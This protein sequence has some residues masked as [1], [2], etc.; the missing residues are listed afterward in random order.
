M[1]PALLSCHSDDEGSI[2]VCDTSAIQGSSLLLI[3]LDTTRADALGCYGGA[4]WVTRNLDE[5]AKQGVRFTQAWTV[6]PLTLPSHATILTGLLPFEHGVRDNAT[7]KLSDEVET[8]AE[9]LKAQGYATYAVMGAFVLH[10]TFGLDQGFDTYSDVPQR[11]L[12]LHEAEDQRSAKEVVDESLKIVKR[13]RKNTPFFMWVHFFDPH[14][15]YRPPA[16]FRLR[17]SGGMPQAFRSK[18]AALSRNY[19]GEVQ[20][21][22]R[23]FGRLMR[24]VRSLRPGEKLLTAVVADH[25]EGLGDHGEDTHAFKLYDTT[26]RVSMILQHDALPAGQRI[27]EP[28]STQ[29]LAPTLLDLLGAGRDGMTGRVLSPLFGTGE[30]LSGPRFAYIETAYPYLNHNWAPLFGLIDWPFK[31]I[32]GPTPEM[33]DLVHDP[34][35]RNNI[36]SEQGERADRMRALFGQLVARTNRSER[37][38]LD[39]EDRSRI[40]AL[41]Y[42]GSLNATNSDDPLF[43]GR[44]MEGLRDPAEGLEI[45]SLCSKARSLVFSTSKSDQQKAVALIEEVLIKDPLNPTFLAHAGS[46][47]FR[48]K[49]YSKAMQVLEKS[50]TK[51]ESPTTR[52]T[53]ATCYQLQGQSWRCLDLLRESVELYP[54]DLVIRFKLGDALLR[55]QEVEEAILHLDFFLEHHA[56]RDDLHRRAEMLRK[57][58]SRGKR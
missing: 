22:D 44:I 18:D 17:T 33:Y 38:E 30:A 12:T 51:L 19:L 16:D 23:E 13:A 6:A 57:S 52:E 49:E 2:P 8:M 24:G 56:A 15:P 32:D 48:L 55:A 40:E 43:P 58:A 29:D 41:G 46:I 54:F 4:S 5:L 1:L 25:G 45:W 42:V 37:I 31:L 47:Y 39:R 53:L 27:T 10:S 3:T 11:Q 21:M 35:E 26:V 28:V 36:I 20:Y 7:F 14:F 34:A 9:R 50:L